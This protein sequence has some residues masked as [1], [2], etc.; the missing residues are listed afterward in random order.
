MRTCGVKMVI[1]PVYV[2][3]MK[4]QAWLNFHSKKKL[5]FSLTTILYKYHGLKAY[6]IAALYEEQAW[7]SAI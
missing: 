3:K 6:T 4:S 1:C 2:Q 5:S 7:I